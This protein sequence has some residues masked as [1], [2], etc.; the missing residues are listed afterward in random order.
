MTLHRFTGLLRR[1][2]ERLDLPQ[3]PYFVG[4]S[5]D[6]V[7]LRFE[8]PQFVRERAS[9]PAL[10]EYPE[11]VELVAFEWDQAEAGTGELMQ[12]RSEWRLKGKVSMPLQFGIRL[13]PQGLPPEQFPLRLSRDGFFTQAFPL[14][15]GERSLG[16]SVEGTVYEQR[17]WFI[18]PTNAAAGTYR[19][20][21]GLGPLYREQYTGWADVGGIEVQARPRPR[22]GP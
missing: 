6:L 20:S 9:G 19:T 15:N 7:A 18:I 16:P 12:F 21:V 8:P 2:H 5:E 13:S 14:A 22:N 10:G 1:I 17:G 3:P 4:L 11:G